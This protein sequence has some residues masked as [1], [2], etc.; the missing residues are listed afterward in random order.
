LSTYCLIIKIIKII[1]I[2]I[3]IIIMFPCFQNYYFKVSKREAQAEVMQEEDEEEEEE[4]IGGRLKCPKFLSENNKLIVCS[5]RKPVT[6]SKSRK[7]D[8]WA[9]RTSQSSLQS[10]ISYISESNNVQWVG[11]PGA[12]VEESTREAVRNR[13]EEERQYSPIFMGKDAQELVEGFWGDVLFPNM[14][15]IPT[16]YLSSQVMMMMLKVDDIL[17]CVCAPPLPPP[18]FFFFF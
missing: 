1:I 7:G 13:L 17:K 18:L 8:A 15:G 3:I 2:I 6:M 16:D 4:L 10:S 12:F 5:V 14:H 11:W 9:Y